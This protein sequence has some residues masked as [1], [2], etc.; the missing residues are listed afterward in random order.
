VRW[1]EGEQLVAQGKREEAIQA[2]SAIPPGHA[3]W[4]A[5][6]LSMMRLDLE[7]L[8][9]LILVADNRG[10]AT[11]WDASRR[12][13]ERARDQASELAEKLTLELAIARVDLTPGSDRADAARQAVLRLQPKLTRDS[14]RQ[15]AE[16]ILILADALLGRSLDLESRLRER[17]LKMD[18]SLVL[19]MCR[20]LDTQA[21]IIDTEGIRKQ[22]G[23]T[24]AR[25]A[26]SL[27]AIS[28]EIGQDDNG[29]LELRKIRGLIYAGQP[30]LAESRMDA[31]LKAHPDISPSL[32][33]AV[34]DALLRLNATAKA[35]SY[36]RIWLSQEPEGGTPWFL[37][38]LE[39]AK[40]L[41]REGRDKEAARLI[42]ATLVLYP[43]A[44]GIGLKRKFD[45]LRRSIK[46]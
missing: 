33:F 21:S 3:R 42:D 14:Q 34:S 45:A 22:L 28:K 37:G 41:Y 9:N 36:L 15:W 13:L 2:W 39:L 17:D 35:I 29:E 44:G 32:L 27:P 40:A 24:M 7:V 43:E 31:W 10:F 1:I 11:R 18:D 46:Y 4:L 8:D 30:S 12:R 23:G 5:A 38:R 20:V 26:E 25:L 19:D 16:C 6:S